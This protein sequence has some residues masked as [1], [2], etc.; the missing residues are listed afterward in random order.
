MGNW[1][2]R[3]Q[4]DK[5]TYQPGDRVRT[6]FWLENT[7]D[8]ILFASEVGLQLEFQQKQNLYY[9]KECS[10]QILPRAAQYVSHLTFEIP[11]TVAGI[12]RYL[13]TYHL[14]EYNYASKVWEDLGPFWEELKWYIKVLPVPYYK[15]F[16]S[17]GLPP[18][19]RLVG[20]QIVQML[21]EWGFETFTVGID[22]VVEPNAL[23]PAVRERITS[24][25]CLI[26][27]ATPRYLD[28]L[29]GYWRTL[30]WLHGETGI[31][32][33]SS[34]PVLILRD[35]AVMVGGLMGELRELSVPY[36]P[37]NLDELRQRLGAI[38]PMFR[39]WIA[40]KRREEFLAGLARIGVPLLIGGIVGFLVG[41]SRRQSQQK[42]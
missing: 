32:F 40:D 26:A 35:Q 16:I 9:R 21:E 22:E 31:A 6:N 28:A 1:I 33:G 25:D 38:M 34:R 20:D 2:L 7:G 17:R 41:S 19:D 5:P 29:S 3:W 42:M 39:Q 4:F 10:A 23:A 14:W 27:I 15:A 12:L 18:E 8:T 24:S 11:K 13:V 30:E 37:L 36:D